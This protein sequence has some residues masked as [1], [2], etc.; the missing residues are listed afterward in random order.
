MKIF[1]LIL[2]I[3]CV[4]LST[5]SAGETSEHEVMAK[6][7]SHSM[8]VFRK[9]SE[10]GSGYNVVLR[11][12]PLEPLIDGQGNVVSATGLHEGLVVQGIIYSEGFKSAL[13]DEQF[14]FVGDTV[15]PYRILQIKPDGFLAQDGE[16]TIF[17]PLYSNTKTQ[18]K[19]ITESANEN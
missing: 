7:L 19:P 11:R 15:G 17:V 14:Y 3:M 1:F 16:K 6:A 13:V 5:A 9:L 2:T 8:E 4:P 10:P 18:E 12:D